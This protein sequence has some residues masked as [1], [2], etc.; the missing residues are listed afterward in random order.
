MSRVFILLEVSRLP[1]PLVIDFLG[2]QEWDLR[3]KY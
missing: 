3:D 2:G 1:E